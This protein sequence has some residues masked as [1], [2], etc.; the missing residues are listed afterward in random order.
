MQNYHWSPFQFPLGSPS[1]EI[2]NRKLLLLAALIKPGIC[3][4]ENNI[5][6]YSVAAKYTSNIFPGDVRAALFWKVLWSAAVHHSSVLSARVSPHANGRPELVLPLMRE[7]KVQQR[8]GWKSCQFGFNW[9]YSLNDPIGG[10]VSLTCNLGVWVRGLS[11]PPATCSI[12]A[13]G[14]LSTVSLCA[15]GITRTR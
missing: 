11:G 15:V 14:C 5:W 2:V 8:S 10:I 3:K 4:K 1:L 9:S 13:Q 6:L 12:L 7:T